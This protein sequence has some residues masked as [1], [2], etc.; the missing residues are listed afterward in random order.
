MT[1]SREAEAGS[2]RRPERSSSSDGVAWAAVVLVLVVCTV[3]AVG[4]FAV[5]ESA[6]AATYTSSCPSAPSAP[7]P[8][9]ITDDAIETRHQ[10]IADVAI[11]EAL[12]ER[13][14]AIV[15]RLEALDD[16]APGTAAQRVA[17]SRVDRD[18][19]DFIGFAGWAMVGLTLVLLI[20][21]KWY[22]SWRFLRE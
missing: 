8:E 20:A 14:A 17:L 13:M 5:T 7:G 11:C 15:T 6:S 3:V 19:L 21:S 12:A 16:A 4:L 2:F 1:P 22:G 18:R 9:E 10:R